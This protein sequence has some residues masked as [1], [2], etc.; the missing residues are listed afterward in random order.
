MKEK[1]CQNVED[2]ID[3]ISHE[4]MFHPVVAEDGHLYDARTI[5]LHFESCRE[6][7]SWFRSPLTNVP[8]GRSLK[9]APEI[10]KKIKEMIDSGAPL[11]D[12]ELVQSWRAA[13]QEV[14]NIK[15]LETK[16]KTGDTTAM[17][18][19]GMLYR[20]GNAPY[21]PNF[22]KAF[23]FFQMAADAGDLDGMALYGECL[24]NKARVEKNDVLEEEGLKVVEFA[25][26]QGHSYAAHVLGYF[27]LRRFDF[28][29]ANH[30]FGQCLVD[31][32]LKHYILLKEEKK[33]IVKL[34]LFIGAW[35]PFVLLA[36]LAGFALF[37]FAILCSFEMLLSW[38][39]G[40][41]NPLIF[42]NLLLLS[43]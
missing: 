34:G 33:E 9:P 18:Q 22:K 31:S 8:M 35:I 20:T 40:I 30:W 4:L 25:A 41:E 11:L 16:T 12:Q 3:P 17:V 43:L 39:L 28:D 42:V 29:L 24:L 15:K 14:C 6:R 27:Y 23:Q 10:M 38:I 2:F 37:L 7:G 21:G 1:D 36:L 26:N 5:L 32:S 13:E 19:L